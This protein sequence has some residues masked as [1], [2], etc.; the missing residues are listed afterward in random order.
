MVDTAFAVGS[1][2]DFSGYQGLAAATA[3]A[4]WRAGSLAP[5]PKLA[6]L[7]GTE[8]LL[9]GRTSTHF[10]ARV[11]ADRVGDESETVPNVDVGA[12]GCWGR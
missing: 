4:L 7:H 1:S 12:E 5:A 2:A 3:E 10:Q 9:V 6:A 11:P 8:R